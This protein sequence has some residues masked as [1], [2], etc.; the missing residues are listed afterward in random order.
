MT[1]VSRSR[2]ALMPG[3]Y[4]YTSL[5]IRGMSM[6]TRREAEH[7]MNRER[8]RGLELG[9]DERGAFDERTQLA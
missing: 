1:R 2:V 4:M 9:A 3:R 7:R 5:P 8:V 6:R